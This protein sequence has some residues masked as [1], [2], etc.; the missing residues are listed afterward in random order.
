MSLSA[1]VSRVI[2]KLAAV[3]CPGR[4]GAENA[5]LGVIAGIAEATDR[6]VVVLRSRAARVVA[7]VQPR[8]LCFRGLAEFKAK[9]SQAL[10]LPVRSQARR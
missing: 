2:T 6:E 5:A 9:L 10:A 3:L 8:E 4:D 7:D 1:R